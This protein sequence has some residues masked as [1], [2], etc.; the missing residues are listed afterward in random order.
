M[1]NVHNSQ[2]LQK[3]EGGK[4]VEKGERE[5]EKERNEGRKEGGR[6]GVKEG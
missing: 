6:E 4:Q 3:V 1:V 2:S 5:R